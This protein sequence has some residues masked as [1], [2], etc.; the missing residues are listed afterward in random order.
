MSNRAFLTCGT[1]ILV[2]CIALLGSPVSRAETILVD[3]GR[4]PV[5]VY[6]PTGYDPETPA[7]LL[8]LLHGYTG[9]GPDTEAYFNFGPYADTNG[10][11]YTYPNGRIDPWGDSFWDA[12]DFCCDRE[13]PNTD[14][15]SIYLLDL[16]EE[17]E[18]AANVDP[19]RIFIAGYSNGGCM[20]YR[21]ACDHSK[22]IAG[23]ISVAGPMFNPWNADGDPANGEDY[24]QPKQPVHVL[25]IHGTADTVAL[26]DG[27]TVQVVPPPLQG[28]PYPGA[29]TSIG[30]WR[31]FNMCRTDV[32]FGTTIDITVQSGNET[33]ITRWISEC[34]VSSSTELWAINGASHGPPFSSTLYPEAIFQFLNSHPR[35]EIQFSDPSTIT[36]PAIP[37]AAS[38]CMYRGFIGDLVDA[39]DDGIPDQEYGS[40]ISQLDPDVTDTVHVDGDEPS[41][42]E[43][44][45]YV[46]SYVDNVLFI[47]G[48]EGGLGKTGAGLHR[49][50]ST[51]CP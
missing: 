20:A 15:D 43:G 39:D 33:D 3:A 19:K 25:H 8:M 45:F 18:A 13:T 11:I 46:L 36:W 29:E 12:T 23:I 51:Q 22:K 16:I 24:C 49:T 2:G 27:G 6:L 28:L 48:N 26:Y 5:E 30:L 35:E 7:P 50:N 41:P 1:G 32:P 21:M 31:A 44:F 4:G 42:G 47:G 14:E 10:Y 9:N 17:I 37:V 40:C 34:H 38:Y